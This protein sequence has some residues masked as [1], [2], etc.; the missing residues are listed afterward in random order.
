VVRFVLASLLLSLS[1]AC[2]S[3]EPRS[4][5]Q[6]AEPE[7]APEPA[8]QPPEQPGPEP[9]VEPSEGDLCDP[10]PTAGD[11]CPPEASWCV[12]DW[13]EPCGASSALW[14]RGGVWEL[15]QERNLCD[16]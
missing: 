16:D 11:P 12:I 9:R 4:Q 7:P 6:L 13:G 10:L 1:I 14:C 5:Q 2:Q 15:E 3:S 8:I